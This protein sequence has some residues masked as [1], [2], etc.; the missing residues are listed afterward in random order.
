MNGLTIVGMLVLVT[1]AY[2]AALSRHRTTDPACT[3][4]RRPRTV[5]G[6]WRYERNRGRACLVC[7]PRGGRRG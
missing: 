3:R 7:F 5:V 1:I 6:R 2:C 4:H